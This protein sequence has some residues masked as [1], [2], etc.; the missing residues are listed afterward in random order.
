[1]K[2]K[3]IGSLFIGALVLGGLCLYEARKVQQARSSAETS[4][5]NASDLQSSLAE[6]SKQTAHLREQLELARAQAAAKTTSAAQSGAARSEPSAATTSQDTKPADPKPAN[7]LAEMFKNPEMKAM[8]RNQQKDVLGPMID[9]NYARLY[10]DLHLSP[11]QAAAFKDLLLNK[12]LGAAEAGMS[13]FAGE[14][15]P[16]KRADLVQR[17]K[18]A[19]DAADTQIEQFLGDDNFAQYQ[20]YEKTLGERMAVNGF[21][22]Q[23]S[24]DSTPLT[25]DQ[26]QQLIQMMTQ[27]REGFKFTTDFSDQSKLSGNSAAMF[28]EDRMNT[29]FQE[30]DQL[31]QQYQAGAQAILSSDQ[32]SA[33][34]KYLNNQ[35]GLQRA[36]MQMAM[37]MF[38]PAKTGGD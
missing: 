23:L 1:M 27:A 5:Q 12:Q 35:Q 26:Q 9:K 34:G 18:A 36:G 15:D 24:A 8:L 30:L 4:L 33:F 7:A 16:A 14:A 25:D 29:Y 31:D 21:R 11:D 3:A 19:N 22:D 6:Q 38:A 2:N 17:I 20:A 37:K 28:T 13:I 10:A 32:L